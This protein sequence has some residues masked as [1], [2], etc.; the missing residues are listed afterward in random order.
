MRDIRLPVVETEICVAKGLKAGD[1]SLYT[2]IRVSSLKDEGK[3][4][5]SWLTPLAVLIVEPKDQYA[6]S[7]TG[8]RMRLE[9]IM[10]LAPSLRAV[11]EKARGAF[12]VPIT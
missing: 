5:G 9:E 4:V 11:V 1:R 2:V 3:I 8:E 12:H 6:I 7:I 10:K